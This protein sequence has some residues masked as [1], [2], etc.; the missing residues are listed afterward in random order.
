MKSVAEA[1]YK[2]DES[3]SPVE[4]EIEGHACP[5][6]PSFAAAAKAAYTCSV[7]LQGRAVCSSTP[8]CLDSSPAL[9]SPYLRIVPNFLSQAQLPTQSNRT[10]TP[11]S[12]YTLN[13]FVKSNFLSEAANW[14]STIGNT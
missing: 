10:R 13:D 12:H 6:P 5:Q 9:G 1:K 2:T 7:K 14:S 8:G 3:I 11:Q 4:T